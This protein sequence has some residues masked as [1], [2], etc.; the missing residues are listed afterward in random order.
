MSS[1]VTISLSAQEREHLDNLIRK[2]NAPARVQTR[3]RILLLSDQSQG[4]HRT[5]QQI[6]DALLCSPSTVGNVRRRFAAQG[7]E[8]ALVEKPRPG[9]RPKITGDIEAQLTLLACSDAPKGHE[10]WTVRLLANKLVEMGCLDSI[11]HVAVYERLK[12]TNLNPGR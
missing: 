3:A 8:A 7:L 12:K 5:E 6:A 1:H 10:R 4:Q 9:Q 2:G 11:S